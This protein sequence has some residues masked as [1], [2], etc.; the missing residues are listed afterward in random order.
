MLPPALPSPAGAVMMVAAVQH[1][2]SLAAAAAPLALAPW[3]Q[4]NAGRQKGALG[5]ARPPLQ[6]ALLQR[7]TALKRAVLGPLAHM[8]QMLAEL[9]QLAADARLCTHLLQASSQRAWQLCCQL[10]VAPLRL[11]AWTGPPAGLLLWEPAAAA[12]A[13]F[14]LPGLPLVWLMPQQ[15]VLE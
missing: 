15:L 14:L 11:P 4:A 9:E 7:L 1:P 13:V 2:P 3:Q 12:L 6:A 5:S 8:A 10:A